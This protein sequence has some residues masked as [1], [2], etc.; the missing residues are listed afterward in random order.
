MSKR[1]FKEQYKV[2]EDHER[3]KVVSP[4]GIIIGYGF[5]NLNNKKVRCIHIFREV[6][7]ELKATEK[8]D[9]NNN[10]KKNIVLS[11]GLATKLNGIFTELSFHTNKIFVRNYIKDTTEI[12]EDIVQKIVD[13][14]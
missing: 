3:F 1:K 4:I 13:R 14:M 11:H 7:Q 8:N 10:F 12:G 5:D 2:T 6:P 9:I